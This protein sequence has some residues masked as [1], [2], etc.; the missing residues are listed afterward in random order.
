MGK[1]ELKFEKYLLRSGSIGPIILSKS[2]IIM[3]Y[4]RFYLTRSHL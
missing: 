2:N 4:W 3:L 1:N